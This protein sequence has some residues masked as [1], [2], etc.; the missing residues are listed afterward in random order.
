MKVSDIFGLFVRATG[1]LIVIYSLWDIWGGFD[2]AFENLLQLNQGGD[3][4][5]SASTL[6]YFIFGVPGLVFGALCFFLA[7]WI[8]KL[9]YRN[10]TQ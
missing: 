4:S 7:D 5:D 1:F 3:N 6:S 10:G 8:V 2:N 9:A